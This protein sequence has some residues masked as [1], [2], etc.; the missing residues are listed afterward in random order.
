MTQP[1]Q[2][3]PAPS[4]SSSSPLTPVAAAPSAAEEL[5]PRRDPR[6]L[7]FFK[8]SLDVGA[9]ERTDTCMTVASGGS[10]KLSDE[11]IVSSVRIRPKYRIRKNEAL[12]GSS[13]DHS[14]GQVLHTISL[15]SPTVVCFSNS[16]VR[17]RP[18][19][20]RSVME[21]FGV[22]G[23][24]VGSAE[25]SAGSA[26]E[27]SAPSRIEGTLDASGSSGCVFC[28]PSAPVDVAGES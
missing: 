28:A 24:C 9:N 16:T 18:E 20:R 13:S 15:S 10:A 23:T 14:P 25:S 5:R 3:P 17:R 11:S 6:F 19:T 21:T 26:I 4:S 1:L 2:Q 27:P 22:A 7:G 8:S 12:G